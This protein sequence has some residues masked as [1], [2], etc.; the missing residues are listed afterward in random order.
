MLTESG[1]VR[2]DIASSFGDFSG[3]AEGVPPRIEM[4]LLDVSGGGSPLA[5][6]AV[7]AWHCDAAGRYSLYH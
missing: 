2:E 6:A 3:V 7:Y 1:V 5:G 4:T